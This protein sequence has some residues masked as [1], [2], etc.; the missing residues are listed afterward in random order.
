MA[1]IMPICAS[2]NRAV[3][4]KAAVSTTR[5]SAIKSQGTDGRRLRSAAS[6]EAIVAAMFALVGEGDLRPS[7][8]RIADRAGLGIR[9]VFRHFDEMDR[10]YAEMTARLRSEL[11][12]LV[13]GATPS[14]GLAK[15]ARDLVARRCDIYER[16]GPYM[17]SAAVHRMRSPFLQKEHRETVEGMRS[18]LERWIPE[19]LG[20]SAREAR[21]VEAAVS[22]EMW[23]R[24]RT[25]QQLGPK[26]TRE[27]VETI[28]EALV[29]SSMK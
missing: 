24:L 27:A 8:Q 14:G 4:R 18:D 6:R 11:H 12:P 3:Q 28:V 19:I 9:T 23:D 13:A 17:R 22:F 5:K 21:A 10:L 20:A 29:S 15:R 7:A 1:P 2:R 26:E 16:T 25:V